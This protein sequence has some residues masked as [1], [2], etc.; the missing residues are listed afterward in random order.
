MRSVSPRI[1]DLTDYTREFLALGEAAFLRGE[2]L[3]G[4]Y[5]IRGAEFCM[6]DNDPKKDPTRRR[7]IRL[8]REQFGIADKDHF[9]VPYGSSALSAYRIAPDN[10]R[11]TLVIHGGFD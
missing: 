1:H 3:K 9:S 5:Y 4:A 11:G 8:M 2:Q 6:F 10:P 7:F